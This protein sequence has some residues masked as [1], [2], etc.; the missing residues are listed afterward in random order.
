MKRVLFLALTAVL[1]GL[2][3]LTMWQDTHREWT[4]YQ[5][6]FF[7]TLE[8][9]ER[10]GL[11]GGIQQVIVS[12][13]HRVDRCTTCHL[14]VDTPQLALAEEPFKAHPGKFLDSHPIEKFGC[15]VCHGGQGLATDVAAAH[16]DVAHWE[17]PLLRGPLVQASCAACHGDL[18]AIR[19]HVPLL[20]K[21]RELFRAKGCYGCHA[22][23]DVG[24]TVSQDVTEIGSKSYLLLEADFEMMDPPHDRIRWLMSKL[25]HPRALN[26]GVRPEQLPPGEEEVFPSAMPHVGLSEAEI[27]ALTVYL[28]SLTA[29]DPPA[30]YVIHAPPE[31]ISVFTSAI[32]RG[33]AV[34]DRLGCAGCHGMGGQGGRKNWNA[35]LR[36][37]IPPLV[38]VKAYY[39]KDVESLK[40]L[41]RQGRQP[42][43]RA[44]PRSPRPPLYMPAWESRLTEDELDAL[45]AYLFSLADQLPQTS[46]AAVSS[47]PDA[48]SN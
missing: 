13:L 27:Q 19:N 15:T 7:K 1:F 20:A 22:I 11:T 30:S 36:E 14:A 3:V 38:Y 8:R 9:H 5:H 43:P 4:R 12:D 47:A 31:P 35:G 39:G 37:E 10:R 6:R 48:A 46:A 16:G 28:L 29:F 33:K 25:T 18:D 34:F 45:I 40:R 42:I 23:N 17:E 44:D 2:F 32:E 21:G 41:I 26:P 24:Q